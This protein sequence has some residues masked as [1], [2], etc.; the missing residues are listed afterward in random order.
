M[1]GKQPRKKVWKKENMLQFSA[2]YLCP[3]TSEYF[4]CVKLTSMSDS[5]YVYLDV[6]VPKEVKTLTTT[7]EMKSKK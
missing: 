1:E 6:N 4:F 7:N 2:Q 3:H 5:L